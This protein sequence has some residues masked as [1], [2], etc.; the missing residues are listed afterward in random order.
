VENVEI[1]KR[2]LRAQNLEQVGRVD[3][4]V[5]LYEQ[6]VEARFDSTGPYDRLITIYAQQARHR[7]VI[8]VASVAI[9]AVRTHQG[10]MSWYR[11]MRDEAERALAQVP[12]PRPR[13]E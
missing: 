2:Y 8:R 9:E 7:E 5:K 1:V 13:S 10:K 6:A 3:D 4:A 11:Q 12:E